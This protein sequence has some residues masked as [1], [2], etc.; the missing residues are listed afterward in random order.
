MTNF[1]GPAVGWNAL[2][3][4][5]PSPR[6]NSAKN[7]A[8]ARNRR[9]A[10]VPWGSAEDDGNHAVCRKASRGLQWMSVDVRLR[11][12]GRVSESNR[13]RLGAD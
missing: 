11:W 12:L 10:S 4:R 8:K 6:F 13:S 7:S 5:R 1:Y 9:T 2:R 3:G